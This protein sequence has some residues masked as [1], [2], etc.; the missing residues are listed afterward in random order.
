[1]CI[2]YPKT[3]RHAVQKAH[4]C[5][6]GMPSRKIIAHVKYQFVLPGLHHVAGEERW[7]RASVRVCSHRLQQLELAF[8][9]MPKLDLQALSG[10]AVRSIKNVSAQLRRHAPR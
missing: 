8:K 9:K 2:G 10:T 7:V 1:M 6:N 5:R 3:D 4:R